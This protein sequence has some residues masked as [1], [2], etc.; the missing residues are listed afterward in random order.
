MSARALLDDLRCRGVLLRADGDCLGVDAPAG[1]ITDEL[2]AS[3]A[4]HKQGLIK[5]LEW[6]QRNFV[7]I[8]DRRGFIA[9]WSRE[10]AWISLLD[11][12]TG[13][14]HDVRAEDCLPGILE[15][16]NVSR[17]MGGAA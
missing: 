7:E 5:L 13:E 9:R 1:A 2:R 11:P 12:T 16:A 15:T 10:P 3:L 6:D 8:D 14:W 4:A 17:K